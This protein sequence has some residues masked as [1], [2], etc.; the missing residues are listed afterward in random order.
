MKT[1]PGWLVDARCFLLAWLFVSTTADARRFLLAGL[2]V[3][4][5]SSRARDHHAAVVDVRFG[6]FSPNVLLRGVA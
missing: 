3:A 4:R 6:F 2:L 1:L 5:W